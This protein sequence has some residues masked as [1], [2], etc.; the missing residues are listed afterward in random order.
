[1]HRKILEHRAAVG[2]V[3]R[4][5]LALLLFCAAG[6]ASLNYPLGGAW[7]I[8]G[9][10]LYAA[11][12]WRYPGV[13]LPA[14]LALLPLLNFAPWSGWLLLN[15]FDL[16]V[17]VTLA[18]RLLR[19][20][21]DIASPALSRGAKWA[22]GLVAASFFVSAWIGL[23]PL[24]PFDA[25][26]LFTYYSSFNSLR[27][28]KGFAWALALLPLLIEEARQPQRLEQR[29]IAGMLL[30]LCAVVAVIVW[31]RAVYTGLLDFAGDYRVE[32]TFPELHTGGGDVHAY[33][34]TALPFVIAW[35]V[36]RPTGGRIALGAALFILA[37][38]T[39]GVT[40]TRGAYVGYCGALVLMGIAMACH[41]ERRRHWK[42]KPVATVA[43]LAVASLAVM[44]PILS[45]SFMEARLAGTQTEATTRTRHWAR[46]IDMMDKDLM[47][48]LFGMGLGS[49]PRAFLFKYPDAASATFSYEREDGN[50]F[51]RLG[52]GK[53]L[54][55]DQ[56]VPVLGGKSYTLSLD[57]RSADPEAKL[58]AALCEKS[59]QYSFRCKAASLQRQGPAT[60]WEH[61][62]LKLDSE[63]VGSAPWVLRRP[64]ALSIANARRG[65]IVDV[66]NVRLLDESGRDLVAN[67]DFSGG[68]S[69]WFF[70]A[71][72]HLPWHIF[73]LWVQ[74]LFEQGWAGAVTLTVAVLMS[75]RRLAI[76]MWRGDLFSATLLAALGGFLLVGLTESL[77]DG[78]RV[79][80]LFFLVLFLGLLRPSV[81]LAAG[82]SLRGVGSVEKIYTPSRSNLCG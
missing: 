18:V 80:T 12:L 20:L 61:R 10:G 4:A 53:P 3:A 22:I 43:V 31:Q 68:G 34:V 9:L 2:R 81:A 78:P 58:A 36:L 17:A 26:A 37:S 49:F 57:M 65:S 19:P 70:S 13:G 15:E 21:A 6:I 74:T 23:S 14:I 16:L 41:G 63:Q 33:L 51:L 38:Y 59:V 75:L 55:L 48:A 54:Y 60:S 30:G 32:G 29:W 44:I 25:N 62:E 82:A 77:F 76:G 69:R 24:S 28:L 5:A 47:T 27:E 46:A 39:I 11:V 66:D 56:R 52:S 40:F 64:V 7:L 71:D 50:G 79:T 35:I 72:D 73:N 1:L 45:G 67:G 8:L 42:V